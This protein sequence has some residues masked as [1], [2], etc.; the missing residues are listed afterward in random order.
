[1]VLHDPDEDG[2]DGLLTLEGRQGKG[3]RVKGSSKG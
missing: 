1:M 3:S 2:G